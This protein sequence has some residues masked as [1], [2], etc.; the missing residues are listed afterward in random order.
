MN[1]GLLWQGAWPVM[2]MM[3]GLIIWAVCFVA[4]YAGMSLACA[5]VAPPPGGHAGLHP[6]NGWLTVL[7]LAHLLPLGWLTWYSWRQSRRAADS[8]T[9]PVRFTLRVTW[10]C[11][12]AALFATVWVGF[13]VVVTVPCA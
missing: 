13:P 11:N 4:L 5:Y 6:I 9:P 12:L 7:W 1:R 10:L 8:T 3:A 2:R